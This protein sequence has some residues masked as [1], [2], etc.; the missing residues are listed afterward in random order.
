VLLTILTGTHLSLKCTWLSKFRTYTIRKLC[1]KKAE[2]IQNQLNLNVHSIGQE[3]AMNKKYKRL[4][5]N[6][7]SIGQEE[8]M[9][10][11]YKRLRL[12]GRQAYFP[13]SD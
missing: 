12:G 1:R 3:E 8:A 11:K 13:S 5:L 4:N 9:N 2:A 7:H 6:V 10:K